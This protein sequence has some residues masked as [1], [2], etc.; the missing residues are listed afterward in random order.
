[1]T[2]YF[3]YTEI[4]SNG[5]ITSCDYFQTAINDY[6]Q[7]CGY[8]NVYNYKQQKSAISVNVFLELV[9]TAALSTEQREE[10]QTDIED[11]EIFIFTKRIT[12]AEKLDSIVNLL[13]TGAH[14]SEII[15]ENI[16][17]LNAYTAND[18]VQLLENPTDIYFEG[19]QIGQLEWLDYAK[20][21]FD[22]NQIIEAINGYNKYYQQTNELA[23]GFNLAVLLSN[24]N[25]DQIS[26]RYYQQLIANG[27]NCHH[28][29]AL[30]YYKLKDYTTALEYIDTVDFKQNHKSYL[31][32]AQILIMLNEY[33]P[34]LLVL[35]E[36]FIYLKHI[37]TLEA[38]R[39]KK[40]FI[41]VNN[42]MLQN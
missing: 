11:T 15:S 38:N 34:A 12:T 19:E 6:L 9:L 3:E 33:K 42:Y 14:I 35:N 22:N 27:Y 5:F 39:I 29:L 25:L 17:K 7:K 28:N 18:I 32:K 4:V 20:Y 41:E 24:L 37:N 1:M 36:G 23:V 2:T 8:L 10:V 26:I 16:D 21:C 31:L 13:M 30:S 40:L